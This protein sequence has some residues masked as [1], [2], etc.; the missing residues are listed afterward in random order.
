MNKLDFLNRTSP[1]VRWVALSV[2][3]LML[4]VLSGCGGGSSSDVD[5][6]G[7]GLGGFGLTAKSTLVIS[8]KDALNLSV[9]R[10]ASDLDH[11]RLQLNQPEAVTNKINLS[12]LD[13][14]GSY[15]AI[16]SG[17][18][19][20]LQRK[21]SSFK[22]SYNNLQ[23]VKNKIMKYKVI[24]TAPDLL[25]P[26]QAFF[27][28]TAEKGSIQVDAGPSRKIRVEGIGVDI[29][30][31]EKVLIAAETTLS[32]QPSL[33][34]QIGG[35]EAQVPI[36]FNL[37]DT[38]APITA[39]FP[40]NNEPLEGP[41]RSKVDIILSNFEGASLT[42]KISELGQEFSTLLAVTS[43]FKTLVSTVTIT[44]SEEGVYLFEYYSTDEAG[45]RE[46]TNEK[47]VTVNFNNNPPVS[48]IDYKGS[49]Q[50]IFAGSSVALSIDMLTSQ[51]GVIHYKIDDEDSRDT[52]TLKSGEVEFVQIGVQGFIP[53]DAT[54]NFEYS[55][56]ISG[57]SVELTK[58]TTSIQL[59]DISINGI[60]KTNFEGSANSILSSGVTLFCDTDNQSIHVSES[61]QNQGK[62]V[63]LLTGPFSP[64]KAAEFACLRLVGGILTVVDEGVNGVC[65]NCTSFK[66]ASGQNCP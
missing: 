33:T 6:Q 8:F 55:A 50:K 46:I 16:S 2:S 57:G 66:N 36:A 41:H 39:A 29:D 44:L 21:L 43:G 15:P 28:S 9:N 45:N 54:V 24:I 37:I 56:E 58:N 10:V 59:T 32:L 26:V 60:I 42:Y 63:T 22:V 52:R 14:M 23:S 27:P 30:G 38:L 19:D 51:T 4:L 13:V 20:E 47:R 11:V 62:L 12:L 53:P 40:S 7:S 31:I 3:V 64:G 61:C 35:G 17:L 65:Q 18:Q 25:F 34:T 5:S 1:T 49:P 48:K